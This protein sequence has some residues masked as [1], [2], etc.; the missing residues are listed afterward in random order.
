MLLGWAYKKSYQTTIISKR[1]KCWSL[2]R[3]IFWNGPKPWKWKTRWVAIK[4]VEAFPPYIKQNNLLLVH[5]TMD[6]T[7]IL[8]GSNCFVEYQLF[9]VIL[10]ITVAFGVRIYDCV[11]DLIFG[12]CNVYICMYMMCTGH[13]SNMRVF[14][15]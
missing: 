6:L 4:I 11:S 12:I 14:I 7:L 8:D 10:L 3:R 13:C 15:L 9:E 1:R 2:I 5:S